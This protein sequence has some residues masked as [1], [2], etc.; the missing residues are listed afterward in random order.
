MH[1][2]GFNP[3]PVLELVGDR[4][5][6]SPT[7]ARI[8]LIVGVAVA[9]EACVWALLEAF[10]E[11]VVVC[12]GIDHATFVWQTILCHVPK[13]VKNITTIASITK[14]VIRSTI[15]KCLARQHHIWSHALLG[16]L[17]AVLN[18]VSAAVR[19]ARS[20]VDWYVLIPRRCAHVVSTI[21]APTK[22]LWQSLKLQQRSWHM[23]LVLRGIQRIALMAVV[24]GLYTA[25]QAQRDNHRK[26]SC[27]LH[28][29]VRQSLCR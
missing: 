14:T 8:T 2:R 21:A 11:Y 4:S 13:H 18:H 20:A 29:G 28:R 1:V 10:W 25:N 22:V 26:Q 7:S 19:P 16:N 12:C 9:A 15:Q 6:D 3:A 17:E 23:I 27:R 24:A 5:L